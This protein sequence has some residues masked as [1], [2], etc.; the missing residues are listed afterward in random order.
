M[1]ETWCV[2]HFCTEEV[3]LSCV[4]KFRAKI[5]MTFWM[6]LYIPIGK[7]LTRQKYLL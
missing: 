5:N 1:I 2:G 3:A 4:E 7:I 6:G